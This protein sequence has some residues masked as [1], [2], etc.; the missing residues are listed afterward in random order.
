[1]KIYELVEQNV[2]S[3]G[4]GAGAPLGPTQPTIPS[5]ANDAQQDDNEDPETMAKDKST[6]QNALN[7]IKPQL[8]VANGGKPLDIPKITDLLLHPDKI[9]NPAYAQALGAAIP[10][11]GDAFKNQQAGKAIQGGVTAGVAA[12][13]KARQMSQQQQQQLNKNNAPPANDTQYQRAAE[14]IR[15]YIDKIETLE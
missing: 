15:Q 14:S 13:A 7:N 1:M 10:G 11:L 2:T 5:T 12:D 6:S 8:V 9:S 3:I 4:P